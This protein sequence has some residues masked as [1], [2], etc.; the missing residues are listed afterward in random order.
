LP[1]QLTEHPGH[2]GHPGR[3]PRQEQLVDL[4][5][6]EAGLVQ[7]EL[8][9][10]ASP[11]QQV[12]RQILELGAR[13]LE[14]PAVTVVGVHQPCLRTLTQRPLGLL[15]LLEQ[16]LE[17]RGVVAGVGPG[18]LGHAADGGVVDD[19]AVPVAPAQ[20]DVAV[21]HERLELAVA[22]LHEGHVERPATKVVDDDRHHALAGRLPA[23]DRPGLVE[24]ALLE[25]VSQRRGGRLV[26]K[27][28]D[29]Q[30]GQLG[31]LAGRLA[32]RVVEVGRHGD[33][34]APDR[35]EPALGVN[36]EPLQDDRRYHLGRDLTARDRLMVIARPHVAL[37]ALGHPV[38]LQERQP[39]R[40]LANDQAV[41]LKENN[42]RG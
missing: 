22:D 27:V 34:H 11:L 2:L 33:D 37:G 3:T 15:G 9:R 24:E 10:D 6:L 32:P 12:R 21:G 40:L 31:G 26:E 5:P 13:Q 20:A 29:L 7:D 4:R 41:V 18:M 25:P 16:G 1:R 28:S 35:A 23:V 19:P 42:R 17:R 36:L 8:R 39:L 14:G 30:A 38:R